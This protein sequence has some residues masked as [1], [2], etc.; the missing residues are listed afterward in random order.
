MQRFRHFRTNRKIDAKMT[1][2][3]DEQSFKIEPGAARVDLFY[4][5]MHFGECRK[6][7]DFSMSLWAAKKIKKNRALGRQGPQSA[8]RLIAE[9]TLLGSRVRGR[10]ARGIV[11]K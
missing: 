7:H 3:S 5:F 11:K 1:S 2:E 6:K 8:P 10:L 4:I 9:P